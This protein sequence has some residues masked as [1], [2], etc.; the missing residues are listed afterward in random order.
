MD[1][2][3]FWYA[4]HNT[5]ILIRPRQPLETFGQ[6][7]LSYHLLT[8]F[9]DEADR[10]RVREGRILAYRPVLITP[11]ALQ[12]SPL[13]GFEG[14]EAGDYL[15]WL[16]ENEQNLAL[17]Q[18]GFKIRKE[19]SQEYRVSERI[20][21]VADRVRDEVRRKGNPLDAVLIGVDRPWEVCLLKLLIEV[22]RHSAPHNAGQ[23]RSDP[24]GTR[25]AIE[26]AFAAARRD[27][28]RIGD[29]AGL[30]EKNG[31]FSEYEDRFFALVR[32]RGRPTR[33]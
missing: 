12:D 18:Y 1:D 29:L 3:D 16:K 2:F 4:V 11:R 7:T 5:R 24:D 17:I 32:A 21:L 6:T 28:A 15:E 13:E 33:G 9:P 26:E 20:Q 31:S 19:L 22:A 14:P 30:L 25:A 10:V 27:P 8:E 23:L